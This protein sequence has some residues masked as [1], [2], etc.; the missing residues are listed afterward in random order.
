MDRESM[1]NEENYRFDI[2][3]Y[4]IVPGVLTE[5]E[6]R[7]C[8]Q[9]IDQVGMT[10]SMLKWPAPHADSFE[11]L[12]DHPV[13]AWYL[14]QL[15]FEEYRLDGG[16]RLI[17]ESTGEEPLTGGNEPREWSRSYYQQNGV[18]F[19][20]G[21]LALWALA[22]AVEGDGGFVLVPASHK[23]YAETPAGVLSGTDDMNLIEQPALKAGDLLLCAET[24]LQGVRP[25]KGKG[26][27]RLL[28]WKYTGQQTRQ[29]RGGDAQEEKKA[30]PAWV[31][32][33]T[34]E[35]R[36]VMGVEERTFPRPLLQ[37]NGETCWLEEQAGVFHPSIY[38]RN[39]D[40]KIDPEEFYY[41]DLCGHLVLRGTMDE[42]VAG[43]GQRGDRGKRRPA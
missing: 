21:V 13:L 5:E 32:E 25:W 9:A 29:S 20:Q 3:G 14:N 24:V 36:A 26:P 15:C 38:I 6:V 42:S 27:Q 8:N 12:R 31:D 41:W 11:Q 35:Q 43:G 7:A 37:S 17:G 34:P 39:P 23:S 1:S 18:R 4:L 16:P 28:A 33:M 22:D 40:P 2:A 10:D 30:P 19:S